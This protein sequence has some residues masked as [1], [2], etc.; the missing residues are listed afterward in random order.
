MK[1]ELQERAD[2]LAANLQRSID[3]CFEVLRSIGQLYGSAEWVGRQDFERF[4]QPV[5]LRHS[6]IQALEWLPRLQ[7]CDRPLFEQTVQTEGYPN[8]QVTERKADGQLTRAAQRPEYFPV[9]YVEP[10]AGNELALGFD[11][12]SDAI[13]RSALERARDTGAIAISGRVE[14]V[15]ETQRQ[16]GFLVILPI[17]RGAPGETIAERRDRLQGF[18]LG[19]FRVA[20]VVRA[21]LSGLNLDNINFFLCDQSDQSDEAFLATYEAQSRT[22]ACQS[23]RGKELSGTP[24]LLARKA[25]CSGQ[26]R[27]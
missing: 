26:F 3:A 12:A 20:D 6:G 8:F 21:S 23:S 4:V 13:R 5:L 27:L 17:Y 24:P 11:L 18:V 2:V 22:S 14:L 16:F 25:V 15:Q 19:V 9:A 1:T 7:E 10:L